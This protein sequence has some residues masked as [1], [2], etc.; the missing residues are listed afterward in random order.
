MPPC[1]LYAMAGVFRLP[2]AVKYKAGDRR[3]RHT[4]MLLPSFRASWLRIFCMSL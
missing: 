2:R 3:K 4:M 1:A